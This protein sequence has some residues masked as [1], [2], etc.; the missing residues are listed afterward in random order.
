MRHYLCLQ[1]SDAASVVGHSKVKNEIHELFF[2]FFS[3]MRFCVR[4]S[5]SVASVFV[6]VGLQASTRCREERKSTTSI[7]HITSMLAPL[8][9]QSRFFYLHNNL[10]HLVKL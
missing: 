5:P 8:D 2:L 6:H 10:R 7:A 9:S 4:P 1:V 3:R